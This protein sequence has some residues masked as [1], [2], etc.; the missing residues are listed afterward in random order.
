LTIL[1]NSQ[2]SGVEI[3]LPDNALTVLFSNQCLFRVVPMADDDVDGV[4]YWELFMPGNMFVSFG[5]GT[6]WS[7]RRSDVAA[8][9]SRDRPSIPAVRAP[10]R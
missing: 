6:R 10:R 9:D 4:P 7:Y 8:S 3:S 5:P 2:V 1:E